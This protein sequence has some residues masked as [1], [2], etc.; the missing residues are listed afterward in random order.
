MRQSAK[1]LC[2]ESERTY[3]PSGTPARARQDRNHVSFAHP[4]SLVP[5][6]PSGTASAS[7]LNDCPFCFRYP[8]RSSLA[9]LT[10][11]YEGTIL[12]V[13]YNGVETGTV[14]VTNLPTA[15]SLG[16]LAMLQRGVHAAASGVLHSGHF[17]RCSADYHWKWDFKGSEDLWWPSRSSVG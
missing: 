5:T 13:V 16:F 8:R 3:V 6:V 1:K 15:V 9:E 14:P 7:A 17:A 10:V 12:A 11:L 4:P 2:S